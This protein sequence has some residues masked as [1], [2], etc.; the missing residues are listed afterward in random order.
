MMVVSHQTDVL[1]VRRAKQK[2]L[3]RQ[4][5]TNASRTPHHIRHS[6]LSMSYRHMSLTMK[7][8]EENVSEIEDEEEVPDYEA[9][10]SDENESQC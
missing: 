10:S 7:V 5:R 2:N 6:F 9:S 1:L 4:N 8:T 3:D